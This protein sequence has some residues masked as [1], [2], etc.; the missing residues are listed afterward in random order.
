MTETT[1]T[2]GWPAWF[3]TALRL[4][5]LVGVLAFLYYGTEFFLERFDLD[6]LY[7][8]WGVPVLVVSAAAFIL[9]LSIP[10]VPGME[11]GVA[12]M[13]LFGVRGVLLVYGATLAALSLSYLV[14][15]FIPLG[16]VGALLGWLH[17]RRAKGFVERLE[18]LSAQERLGLLL[19][20]SPGRLVPFLVRHRYIAVAV[21]LNLPGN[22]VI[23]GGGGI[24]LL[25]GVSGIFSYPRYLLMAAI[26]I[27]PLPLMF[28]AKYYWV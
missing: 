27:L 20:V 26:A 6:R 23:G 14:G 2:N 12:M 10:F 7:E 8:R 24:G 3:K 22:A 4:L 1:R 13:M 11:L 16:A 25:A 5:L 19:E 18:R 15:R 28:L 21:V 9:L 17:L